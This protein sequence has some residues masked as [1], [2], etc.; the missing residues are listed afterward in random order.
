MPEWIKL[1]IPGSLALIM[2]GM[3]LTLKVEDFTRIARY[4]KAVLGGLVGQI[5]MLPALAFAMAVGLDLEPLLAVGIMLI[6]LSPG[7]AVSNLFTLLAKGNVALAVTLTAMSS[8]LGVVTIPYLL[9][10][11][12]GYFLNERQMIYLP[13]LPTMQQIA[14]ITV[15]PIGIG[16]VIRSRFPDKVGGAQTLVKILSAAFLLG[17]V[18]LIVVREGQAFFDKLRLVGTLT[19]ALN[20]LTVIMGYGIGLLLRLKHRDALTL[21]IEIGIHNAILA[22]AIALAPSMLNN[23][24]IAMVPTI[25]G[26]TMMLVTPA[27]VYVLSW[28]RNDDD[29]I[30]SQPAREGT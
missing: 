19:A 30:E 26:F 6:A 7:G 18:A 4:P 27:A 14:Y 5:V 17:A 28:L 9:N 13:I 16:M 29:E 24:A 8:L 12:L 23:T 22:T 25:Y 10:L 11:F 1:V 20:L 21:A 2:L 15:I 3:G